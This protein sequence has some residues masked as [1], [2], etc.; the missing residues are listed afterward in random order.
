MTF[1]LVRADVDD[2][3]KQLIMCI[4]IASFYT[5]Q[6]TLLPA[7]LKKCTINEQQEMRGCSLKPYIITPKSFE[8]LLQ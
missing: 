6:K 7:V 3:D 4:E 1:V 8:K 5:T 2:K